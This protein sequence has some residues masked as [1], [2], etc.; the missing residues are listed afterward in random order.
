MADGGD[1]AGVQRALHGELR[2]GGLCWGLFTH[3]AAARLGMNAT[4]LQCLDLLAASGPLTAGQIA[5]QT[6]L[7]TGAVTGVVDRLVE[8][9]LARRAVDPAD[10]RRV[11]VEV[12]DGSSN[13]VADVYAPLS[14]AAAALMSRYAAEELATVLDFAREYHALLLD[15][16]ARLRAESTMPAA[17]TG[18]LATP[19]GP[20]QAG[21]LIVSAGH[22][23]I[24][25][26]DPAQSS[27]Y[28]A[29]FYGVVPDVRVEGG[30]VT[31]T[32]RGST[33]PHGAARITL[34]AGIPW[35]V[36]LQGGVSRFTL[37]L[38][39]LDLRTLEIGGGASRGMVTL[40]VPRAGLPVRISGG[41]R[42]VNVTRPAAA[43]LRLRIH[44]GASRLMVDGQRLG[45]VQGA[46]EWRSAAGGDA[47]AF[48]DV[49]VSGGA[50]AVTFETS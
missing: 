11:M 42:H 13:A 45:R 23:L 4:D 2:R 5:A 47:G 36:R 26:S 34:H 35:H 28:R 46:T 25:D 3:A 43:G 48:V 22:K 30:T 44:G 20:V 21:E 39:G 7:S 6:G 15:E 37:N 12:V 38:S 32:A 40:P 19:L 41:A 33:P 27:L 50:S 9:A 49:E 1:R 16:S 18:E 29:Q 10:R 8:A 24:V 17:G 14:G 31:V